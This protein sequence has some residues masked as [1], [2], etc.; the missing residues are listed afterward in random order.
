VP[1]GTLGETKQCNVEAC[2]KNCVLREWTEWNACSKDCDGGTRKRE[3]FISEEAEGSGTCAGKWSVD[4]LE[5]KEC[6]DHRC[7]VV[8]PTKVMPCNKTLD[9]ILLLDQTPKHGKKGWAA[10]VKAATQ[11][12]DA[13]AGDTVT[14]KPKFSIIGYTGP[15]TWSGVS[16][17]AGSN[18][19]LDVEKTCKVVIKKHFSDDLKKVKEII[20]GMTF[21][22]GTKLLSLALMSVDS[23]LA[24]GDPKS[25]TVVIVFIDGEPLSYRKTL[26]ASREI[27]KKAR[28]LY[29]PIKKFSPF[30]DMKKW[31]SRRW[32]ENLVA[33]ESTK[34]LEEPAT[35]THLIANICPGSFKVKKVSVEEKAAAK[36]K[37]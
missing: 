5:Y 35:G 31:T 23:E 19:K 2:E 24:L 12:I 4:R 22:P 36:A 16:K 27:R 15:R 29:V 1:C 10:E 6:N 20:N 33:V 14:A 25:Q 11:F 34:E 21:T 26:L 13:F 30:A 9:I 28:L 32:E 7:K 37:R 8:D 3:K 18:P 17:C